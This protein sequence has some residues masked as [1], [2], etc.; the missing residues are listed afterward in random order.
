MSIKYY[1]YAAV[2]FSFLLLMAGCKDDD[3]AIPEPK[4]T[5][6]NDVIKRSLGPN[7]VG[8]QIEFA[9]AMALPATKGKLVSAQVEA[10]VAGAPA[11]YLEHRSFYTNSGG[12]DVGIQVGDPS[13]NKDNI[14]T[15]NFTR[16]TM[17]STLRYFYVVPEE[18]RGKEV[19]FTFS[20]KSSNGETAS[21]SMG[22]YTVSKMD[23]KLDLKPVDNAA[24]YISIEDLA[25]YTA[26]DAAARANK[27]D[28]VYIYRAQATYS[29]SIVS[30]GSDPQY[31]PGVTLPA[32]VNRVTKLQ[33]TWNLQ[34]QQLARL[35]YGVFV[36]DPDFQTK[37]FESASD[38]A[39][40]L[41]A[42]AGLW[43]ET[44]DGK[45]RAYIF[46]NS[47]NN[48]GKSATISIKRYQMK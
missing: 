34:D 32:G 21:Y 2:L 43:V 25:I 13:V 23:I 24:C 7:L 33:R 12:T 30:P 5:L 8:G 41:K 15:V 19:K 20:V 26:A 46:I 6:Q 4:G 10:S 9:Y 14:T 37:G 35:K 11:T 42:E 27:I 29:H 28:L 1:Q 48:A 18:I 3:Y 31:L 17:A 45:Y 39:V 36:D 44:A 40:N 47:L 22:P 16:D 38:Y